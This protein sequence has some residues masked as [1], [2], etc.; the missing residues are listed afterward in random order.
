MG[1]AFRE[2]L[3]QQRSSGG[4]MQ[5]LMQALQLNES[6]KYRK[7]QE[8]EHALRSAGAESGLLDASTA[9]VEGL[10]KED[11]SQLGA[12]P[13]LATQTMPTYIKKKQ[14]IQDTLRGQTQESFKGG[15]PQVYKI[16]PQQ[17]R[18]LE[19]ARDTDYQTSYLPQRNMQIA[20]AISGI[21]DPDVKMD[22]Q[23]FLEEYQGN[24][25]AGMEVFK[26]QQGEALAASG[27]PR[28]YALK[29]T[30]EEA[31]TTSAQAGAR[32]ATAQATLEEH[33]VEKLPLEDQLAETRLNSAKL[34]QQVR[35]QQLRVEKY[36]TGAGTLPSTSPE[37][38][39]TQQRLA[40]GKQ[41]LTH[42]NM[43][44]QQMQQKQ[45]GEMKAR[46]LM[47][48]YGSNP[49]PEQMRE[50][51]LAYG[52]E[53]SAEQ[54]MRLNETELRNRIMAQPRIDQIA[55]NMFDRASKNNYQ[56][57]VMFANEL[58][59]LHRDL[60]GPTRPVYSVQTAPGIF[61]DSVTVDSITLPRADA[62]AYEAGTFAKT[63][64]N[65]H[66]DPRQ[67]EVA[68]AKQ[69]A[70][71]YSMYRDQPEMI[72]KVLE[73]DFAAIPNEMR[74]RV[75]QGFVRLTGRGGGATRLRPAPPVKKPDPNA[76]TPIV[77]PLITDQFTPPTQDEEE[78]S[79]E[80]SRRAMRGR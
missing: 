69:A 55:T 20:R 6:L 74:E 75:V 80:R 14:E 44:I 8:Q 3:N 37:V 72:R 30:K 21:A 2:P 38:Q 76:P 52:T 62:D 71:Q 24:V 79:L 50:I 57:T 22:A 26:K 65:E 34:E 23:R 29:Q 25:A 48:K 15:K 5:N 11:M 43:L 67:R 53:G 4:G 32:T 42:T 40:L 61:K 13:E 46:G 9:S 63:A 7:M 73:R 77:G 59:G 10:F 41:Q 28:A 78:A 16:N 33:R 45:A 70:I 49:T 68:L 12:D 66:A 51:V 60:M 47:A 64:A 27:A 36:K 1:G 31:D 58:N 35:E 56:S 17:K 39:E 54:L 18:D 19:Q